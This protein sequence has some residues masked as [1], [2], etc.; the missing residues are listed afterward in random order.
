MANWEGGWG[1]RLRGIST[2]CVFSRTMAVNHY[3]KEKPIG[4]G[5]ILHPTGTHVSGVISNRIEVLAE[6]ISMTKIQHQR[7][8]E[9]CYNQPFWGELVLYPGGLGTSNLSRHQFLS[10]QERELPRQHLPA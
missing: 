1:G 9:L 6:T 7:L 10:L 8:S 5:N 3:A 2:L 4:I